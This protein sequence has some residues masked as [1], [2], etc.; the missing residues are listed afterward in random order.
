M[1]EGRALYAV[2][3]Q[4]HV[5]PVVRSRDMGPASRRIEHVAPRVL[6]DSSASDDELVI[7]RDVGIQLVVVVRVRS[8]A[9]ENAV[10]TRIAKRRLDR[11]RSAEI[12]RIVRPGIVYEQGVSA[13]GE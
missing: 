13:I 1:G 3:V 2:R 7:P 6:L 11:K 8:F 10:Q 4:N 9:E 5:L 12:K